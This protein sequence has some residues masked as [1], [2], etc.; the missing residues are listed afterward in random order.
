MT[1]MAEH[2]LSTQ[3]R[4]CT[5]PEQQNGGCASAATTQ[6]RVTKELFSQRVVTKWVEQSTWTHEE[7]KITE[8]IQYFLHNK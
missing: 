8:F 6:A 4:T 7:Y 3:T 2:G 1:W 5:E